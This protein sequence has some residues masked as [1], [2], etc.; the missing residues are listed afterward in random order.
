MAHKNYGNK[1]NLSLL[2]LVSNGIIKLGDNKN[3]YHPKREDL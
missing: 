1:A 3:M 2:Q